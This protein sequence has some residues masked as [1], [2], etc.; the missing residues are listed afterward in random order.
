MT[1]MQTTSSTPVKFLKDA[2]LPALFQAFDRSSIT[3]QQR[4]TNQIRV[5]MWLLIVATVAGIFTVKLTIGSAT[6]DWAGV[7]AALAFF[8]G[9]VVQLMRSNGKADQDWYNGRAIAE[10]T[11]TLAWRYAVGG[12]PFGKDT[13]PNAEDA[14]KL[15]LKRFSDMLSK[16]PHHDGSA[17]PPVDIDQI[18]PAMKHLRDQTLP[19]RR[20]AYAEGRIQNQL[21]WYNQK[22]ITNQRAANGWNILLILLEIGGFLLALFKGL[23][24][25][26]IDLLGLT[27][28]LA[29]AVV[30]WLQ[31]KQHQ[32]LARSYSVT[33][34]ELATINN[35]IPLQQTEAD[36]ASFVDDAEGAISREHTLWIA[37][38]SAR[39][40]TI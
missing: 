17:L 34:L 35:Q 25:L 15:L 24:L 18:T 14:D 19:E 5:Q 23:G 21:T 40:S 3:G 10:S 20:A 31:M 33:A 8:V 30:T 22:A 7:L 11:K 6:A 13:Y 29:A 1:T 9:L 37:S 32:T 4:L 28:T 36:W 26:S 2:E 27:G 38:R 16:I 39:L 12:N